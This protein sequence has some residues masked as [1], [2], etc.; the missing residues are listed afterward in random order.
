MHEHPT[1]L[2]FMV[3]HGA[4]LR[5]ISDRFNT[6][7]NDFS[8]F[9]GTDVGIFMFVVGEKLKNHGLILWWFEKFLEIVGTRA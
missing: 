6:D 9:M 7:L 4:E 1:V 8:A 5:I 2:E 3:E